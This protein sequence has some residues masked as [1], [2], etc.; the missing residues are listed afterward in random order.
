MT[1]VHV[2]HNLLFAA[3]WDKVV[4]AVDLKSA[5]VDRSFVASRESI[6]CLHL[7]DKWLFLGGIDPVIRAFDLTTGQVKEFHGHKGWVTT[8]THYAK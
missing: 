7:Y 2:E 6:L 3:G 4:R 8:L 5:E 1:R